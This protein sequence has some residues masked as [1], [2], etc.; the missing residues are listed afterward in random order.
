MPLH[1]TGDQV[2]NQNL[3]Q[4]EQSLSALASAGTA[5]V[6]TPTQVAPGDP[7][8][9]GSLY[10]VA[11]TPGAPNDKV[12]AQVTGIT[13]AQKADPPDSYMGGDTVMVDANAK[14]SKSAT[15]PIGICV[16]DS[17]ASSATVRTLLTP[18]P[19]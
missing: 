19:S 14:A 9:L 1:Y 10:C 15:T 6:I 4:I 5:Q 3:A 17:D 18:S 12:A 11:L 8:L 13:Q 2:M 16:E 7:F